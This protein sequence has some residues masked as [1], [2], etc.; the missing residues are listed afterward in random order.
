MSIKFQTVTGESVAHLFWA[1]FAAR[2]A[3]NSACLDVPAFASAKTLEVDTTLNSC[4]SPQV[5]YCT[6]RSK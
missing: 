2:A 5:K 4:T 6:H 3:S 1:P